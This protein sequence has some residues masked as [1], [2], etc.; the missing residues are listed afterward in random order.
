[1]RYQIKKVI[2]HQSWKAIF[3]NSC[4]L[5]ETT[6]SITLAVP[7][8]MADLAQETYGNLIKSLTAKETIIVP[9]TDDMSHITQ[10]TFS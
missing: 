1:M 6:R 8:D 7:R 9:G 2:T 3:S 5:N 4:G 10:D